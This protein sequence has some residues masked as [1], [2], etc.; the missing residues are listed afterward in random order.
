MRSRRG[1]EG[2]R[3]VIWTARQRIGLTFVTAALM[4]YLGIRCAANREY[5]SDLLPEAGPR[6]AELP[7]RVNA[8]TADAGMLAAIPGMGKLL[9][10]RIVAEREAFVAANPGATPYVNLDDLRRVKGMGPATL[11]KLEP[12]LV[13]EGEDRPGTER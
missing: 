13:F 5:V 11:K 1:D 12:Y 10:E 2:A 4:V 6:A 9:A 8:N 3:A 7:E